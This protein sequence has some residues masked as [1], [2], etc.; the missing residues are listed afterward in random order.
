VA[1][2]AETRAS[3]NRPSQARGRV[4]PWLPCLV[5]VLLL[6][7]PALGADLPSPKG[8]IEVRTENFVLY[9][10]ASPGKTKKLA[11][12][13]E[14]FR[15]VLGL[16]TKGFDLEASVPTSVY[17][18]KNEASLL[19]Y[20]LDASGNPQNLVGYFL[21]RRFRNYIALDVSASAE[22]SRVIYHE[23]V[24]SMLH[25]TFGSMPQWLD[26]GLAE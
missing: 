24:H 19:P 15:E 4:G 1:V 10:N 6:A 9:S 21:R 2:R 12:D 7:W 25:E 5:L 14:R 23:Y 18:F 13:L 26:E 16:I 22:R 3:R 17:V 20:K 8:W 11:T